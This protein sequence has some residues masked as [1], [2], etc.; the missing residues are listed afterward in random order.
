MKIVIKI[1]DHFQLNLIQIEN[2]GKIKQQEIV[3]SLNKEKISLHEEVK[4]IEREYITILGIFAAIMLAFVGGFTFSTSVLNNINKADVYTLTLIALIIGLVFVILVS[5]LIDF[6]R[7]INEKKKDTDGKRKTNRVC[8]FSI[9]ILVILIVISIIGYV[10]SSS[11]LEYKN[12]SES[13]IESQIV[14]R[15]EVETVK[16]DDLMLTSNENSAVN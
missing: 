1:Y 14:S 5:I 13:Q 10:M 9:I 16:D 15:S 3:E 11:T 6:L 2:I 4:R 8:I 7:E 12:I